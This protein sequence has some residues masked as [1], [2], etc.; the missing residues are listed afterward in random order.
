VWSCAEL[1][2]R[3]GISRALPA[4]AAI[5][6]VLLAVAAH[7]QVAYWLGNVPLFEHALA[8]TSRQNKMA[9]FNLAAGYMERGDYAAAQ[10]EYELAGNLQSASAGRYS[11]LTSLGS[12]EFKRGAFA[13]AQRHL[14]EA[15]RLMPEDYEGR[16]NYGTLL[17][18]LN[19]DEEAA[20]QF[21]Y[22]A[23]LRPQ[24]AEPL[25]YAALIAAKARRF[26]AAASDIQRAIAVDHDGS[27]RVLI[28]AI[29]IPPRPAAIDEYLAF[30]RRQSGGH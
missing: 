10:R 26:D 13:D 28:G 19:R 15:V 3:F 29:R 4:A 2:P 17:T 9:H 11:A 5:A 14:A 24:S 7:A 30:L 8:V 6:I 16:M 25:V 23:K 12:D 21:S 27:N 22:A 1:A 18:R 20:E